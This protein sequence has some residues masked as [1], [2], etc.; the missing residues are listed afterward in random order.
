[1]KKENIKSWQDAAHWA[2]QSLQALGTQNNSLKELIDDQRSLF[3]EKAPTHE[4][5]ADVYTATQKRA[6]VPIEDSELI[7]LIALKQSWYGPY[8]ILAFGT[9][10][11]LIR[12]SDKFARLENLEQ[13]QVNPEEE[14]IRDTLLDLCGYC[15]IG[16][17]VKNDLMEIPLIS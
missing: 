13:L 3:P 1:M 2:L 15:I 12:I 11:I 10:G 16:V 4:W 6:E 5:L 17:M 9:L 8:N 14:T 7:S